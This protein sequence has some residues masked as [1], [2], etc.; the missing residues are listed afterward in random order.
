MSWMSGLRR[1]FKFSAERLSENAKTIS[2]SPWKLTI[3]Q[4][5]A[6]KGQEVL[7]S[8]AEKSKI[9]WHFTFEW[10]IFRLSIDWRSFVF[11]IFAI[12]LQIF[13]TGKKN[14]Q[15][16]FTFTEQIDG[17]YGSAMR[18]HTV[19]VNTLRCTL[20]FIHIIS[21]HTPKYPMDEVTIEIS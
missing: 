19:S 13:E 3:L 12:F 17:F 6:N 18:N 16:N 10:C 8:F 20:W 4:C 7:K 11:P 1:K 9:F 15:K 14:P 5:V 2:L 21:K